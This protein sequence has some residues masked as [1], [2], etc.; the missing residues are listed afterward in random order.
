[1]PLGD[2]LGPLLLKTN[3]SNGEY[4]IALTESI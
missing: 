2:M 4:I 3:I 1:M